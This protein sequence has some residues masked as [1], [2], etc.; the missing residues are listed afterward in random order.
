MYVFDPNLSFVTFLRNYYDEIFS[1]YLEYSAFRISR[2]Y[3]SQNIP[4]FAGP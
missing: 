2:N 4:P 3:K 1:I